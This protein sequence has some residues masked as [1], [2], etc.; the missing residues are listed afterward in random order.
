MVAPAERSWS[1]KAP[2]DGPWDAVVIGTG[3]GS[4]TT[5]AALAQLGKRVLLLE[6][7]YVPGGY[8]HA[9]RRKGYT[10]DA[11]VH[12]IGEMSEK[13]MPGRLMNRLTGGR[14]Q[15]EELG[16]PFES[17]FFP[18]EEPF[19]FANRLDA[20]K[21]NLKDRFPDEAK[22]IDAFF[23][24][25]RAATKAMGA[26]FPT[27]TMPLLAAKVARPIAGRRF[28]KDL[29]RT[30]AQ[31]TASHV[32]TPLLQSILNGQ[33]GYHG[34]IPTEAAW[35][36]MAMIHRHYA[37]GAYYPVGGSERIAVELLKTVAEAGGWTRIVAPVD[38]I[39]LVKG[40]AVGVVLADGE[41]IR[42]PIVI[43][44][45]GAHNTLRKL[46]PDEVRR[47]EWAKSILAL[48]TSPAHLGLNIGFKGDITR[49]GA[50]R[51]SQWYYNS[52]G[53]EHT[54]WEMEPGKPVPEPDCLFT[55]FPSLKDPHHDPGPDQRH[56][57]EIV[58]FVRPEVFAKWAGTDWRRR[59][60]DYEAFKEEIAQRML[61]VL[62]RHRP[63]L[64]PMVDHH[65][66][67][68]PLST[69]KFVGAWGGGIYG[70]AATKDRWLN[71]HLRPRT[72]IPGLIL[73][74]TDIA[75]CGVVG[76]FMGGMLAAASVEPRGVLPMMKS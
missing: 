23:D 16:S 4:M 42:A 12:L 64:K 68:T 60:D 8:T 52:I 62:F 55:S 72:P 29:Q 61:D 66:L 37:Y 17:F 63:E 35:P 7:H 67:S 31:V 2:H 1:K 71:P 25:S 57:G 46:L 59:G 3:I 51:A 48:P 28:F 13:A 10:W 5:A 26:W 6:Q 70:L 18:D 30:T 39:K 65:E 41:E 32:K 15:W 40:R 56:T 74:G 14:L 47:Q 11:G 73:T 22:G 44:G 43:S 34:S 27:Q 45:A 76:G 38:H 33:W 58:T 9:F 19:Y 75:L 20:H 69:D 53:H 54:Y 50:T 36:M 49:A 21:D 24:D